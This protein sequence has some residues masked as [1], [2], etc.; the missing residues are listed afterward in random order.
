MSP[1]DDFPSFLVLLST[2][3]FR[4]SLTYRP[5]DSESPGLIEREKVPSG[6]TKSDKKMIVVL[7]S[8]HSIKK[9]VLA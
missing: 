8:H 4:F 6:D 9:K 7:T 2:Q 3:N 1:F 5:S